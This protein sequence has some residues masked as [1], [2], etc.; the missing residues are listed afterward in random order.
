MGKLIKLTARSS[1]DTVYINVGRIVSIID[2][3]RTT[4]IVHSTGG[5]GEYAESTTTV[6]SLIEGA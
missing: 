4:K 2:R 5:A 1:G 3:N 6:L